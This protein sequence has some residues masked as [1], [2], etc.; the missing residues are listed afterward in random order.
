[1]VALLSDALAGGGSEAELS[2]FPEQIAH[3]LDTQENAQQAARELRGLR[4]CAVIGR[5]Y[6]SA[7]IREW[8]LKLKEMALVMADP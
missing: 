5:G 4:Q 2:A 6:N 3:A 8:A 7:T 1:M